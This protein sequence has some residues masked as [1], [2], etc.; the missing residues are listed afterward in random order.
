MKRFNT[1]VATVAGMSLLLGANAFADGKTGRRGDS[2]GG[3]PMAPTVEDHANY[4]APSRK[5]ISKEDLKRA[6][7]LRLKTISSIRQLLDE[8]SEKSGRHFE[9]ILRLGEVYVERHDYLRDLEVEAFDKAWVAWEEKAKDKRGKAPELSQKKSQTEL[10]KAV[11]AFRKLVN[12]YPKHPRTDAALYA[13]AKTL[14]RMGNDNAVQYYK[15][16]INSHP[17]SPL[18]PDAWLALGE[19]YFDKHKIDDAMTAY[20]AA[21]KFKDHPA[22]HYAVYKLGWAHFN[23]DAKSED[24]SKENMKKAIAAFKLV[25]KLA[26]AD[27]EKKKTNLDLRDEAVRDL[28]MVWA[29]TEDIDSAWAYF[30]TIGEQDAFYNMLE[31][32]GGIYAEQG[33]N[34]QA[35]TVFNRLLRE[36]PRRAGN[37]RIHAKLVELQ[38]VTGNTQGAVADL[39]EMK[40]LYTEQSPWT[41]ANRADS[42][43]TSKAGELVE[44]NLHRW[45]TLFHS[46][47]QKAK[48]K[49]FMNAAANVYATYLEAFEANANA[50]DIRFYLAEILYDFE[51]YE[52]ASKH[53]MIVAKA[54]PKNGKHLKVA[55]VN[56]VAAMT[57]LVAATKFDKLPP[58]GQATR[59]FEIPRVK[60]ALVNTIDDYVALLPKEQDGFG[61]RFTAAQIWFE[62]GHYADANRR[63]EG[64]IKEIPTSKQAQASA[65][66]LIAFHADKEQ[67]DDVIGRGKSF[68]QNK[69]LMTNAELKKYV[70]DIVK[71]ATFKRALAFERDKQFEKAAV[72][73]L[74]FQKEYAKDPSADR[75]LYNATLN[76]NKVGK[77][78]ESIAASKTLLEEYPKSSLRPDLM[79]TLAET[80]EAIAQF[81]N[82]A[83]YYRMFAANYPSDKRAPGALYNSAVLFKGLNNH[84]MASKSFTAFVAAYPQHQLT[85]DALTELAGVLERDGKFGDA[86]AAWTRFAGL[87]GQPR[88]RVLYAQAKSAEIRLIKLGQAG[89][90]KDLDRLLSTL[91]AQN[92]APAF[93]ARQVVAGT[94][95]RTIDP[96]FGEYRA[97][98]VTNAAQIEKQIQRKQAKLEELAGGYE[99]II[100]VASAEF[101]VASLYRLGE[102]HEDFAAAL[103]KAPGPAGATQSDVDK[104]KSQLEK[105]AF[106][107]REEAYKFYEAAFKRS[108]EVETFTPW[109]RRTYAKMVELQPQKHPEVDEQSAEPA[110]LTHKVSLSDATSILAE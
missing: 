10:S 75:A 66:I 35:I 76:F 87:S 12:E 47:G 29:E 71:H 21:M 90:R 67:W 28:V 24:A 105:L 33:K 98:T 32:L 53:Y 25:I 107:L 51:K 44:F 70:D 85:G 37:P 30:R 14:G 72:A 81:D 103:F 34:G 96:G 62:H 99:T 18:I 79:A 102:M 78:E 69:P 36:S 1:L 17:K 50:Y 100:G 2:S 4:F 42:E 3:K 15:Q 65:R 22:Y 27:K 110:Y 45:G 23:A 8:K 77:L 38:D 11:N 59:E 16:L 106:P 91:S 13:L 43:T 74:A 60:V 73:F 94:L 52:Q 86:A 19:F 109:T 97:M 31:R 49:N 46:R 83:T 39:Q 26:A 89:A 80:Y 93:E 41:L 20:R 84:D 63:F 108:Q 7:D 40:K 104:F 54:Q 61:M 88:D 55:A 48:N 92:A 68:A 6:D 57:K 101:T 56:A 64:I 5:D 58:P 95:F 9:L 82:A